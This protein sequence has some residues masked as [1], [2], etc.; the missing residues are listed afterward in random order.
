MIYILAAVALIIIAI[1]VF[2]IALPQFTGQATEGSDVIADQNPETQPEVNNE[3]PP[4]QESAPEETPAAEEPI[5]EPEPAPEFIPVSDM[6]DLAIISLN[7]EPLFPKTNEEITFTAEIQ[8]IGGQAAQLRRYK[9]LPLSESAT[10]V[11]DVVVSD[12]FLEP[13]QITIMTSV[14]KLP[15]GPTDVAAGVDVF[16]EIEEFDE[17]NNEMRL[18]FRVQPAYGFVGCREFNTNVCDDVLKVDA[19]YFS[20]YPECVQISCD[21]PAS[22]KCSDACPHPRS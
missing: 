5:P 3:E 18:K 13:D 16:N 19:Q 14:W 8:N 17:E 7:F 6:P 12:D 22:V 21:S 2:A 11:Q 9:L 10:M 15:P 4:A 20:K 1:G